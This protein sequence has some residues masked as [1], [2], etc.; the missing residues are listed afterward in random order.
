[1]AIQAQEGTLQYIAS[2]VGIITPFVIG[3]LGYVM[4]KFKLDIAN[5]KVA[6]VKEMEDKFL[7][8]GEHCIV[9]RDHEGWIQRN[10]E[11]LRKAKEQHH[12]LHEEF[13]AHI[14]LTKK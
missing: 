4:L 13:I 3:F 1:M 6:L 10:E 14:N 8:R 5:L 2:I 11:A 7:P 12:I 9:L